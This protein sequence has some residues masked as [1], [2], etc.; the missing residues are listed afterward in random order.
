MHE[1]GAASAWRWLGNTGLRRLYRAANPEIGRELIP[2]PKVATLQK[3]RASF[4]GDVEQLSRLLNRDL[5]KW[6]P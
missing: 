6:M 2:E 1:M 4:A 5:S 3:L